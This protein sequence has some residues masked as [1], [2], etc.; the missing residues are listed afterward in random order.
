[1]KAAQVHGAVIRTRAALYD[2][3]PVMQGKIPRLCGAQRLPGQYMDPGWQMAIETSGQTALLPTQRGIFRIPI[4]WW[5][6][7]NELR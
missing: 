1:V 5:K 4:R 7:K 2:T 6:K 3:A